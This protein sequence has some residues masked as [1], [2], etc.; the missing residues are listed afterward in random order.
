MIITITLEVM[1]EMVQGTK[2]Q[3]PLVMAR[4]GLVALQAVMEEL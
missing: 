3:A 1:V 4:V 2:T